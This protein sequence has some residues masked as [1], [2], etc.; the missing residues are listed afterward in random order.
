MLWRHLHRVLDFFDRRMPGTGGKTILR[1]D[2]EKKT[3]KIRENTNT[4][5]GLLTLALCTP[6][7]LISFQP[8]SL[9]CQMTL[10]IFS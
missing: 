4:R 5:G 7:S 9:I 1:Y 10:K 3:V 6:S 8:P 2:L